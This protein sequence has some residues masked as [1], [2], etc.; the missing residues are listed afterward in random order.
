MY[1]YMAAEKL[2]NAQQMANTWIRGSSS[3]SY[4]SILDV[5]RNISTQVQQQ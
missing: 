2:Q 3:S 1:K 5:D 4:S